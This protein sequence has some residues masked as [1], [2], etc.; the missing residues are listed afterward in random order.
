MFQLIY[1][2]VQF[3]RKCFSGWWD[4]VAW[5]RRIA[6]LDFLLSSRMQRKILVSSLHGWMHATFENLLTT[7]AKCHDELVETQ[8]I[9]VTIFKIAKVIEYGL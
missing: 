3:A 6:H 5:R 4:L 2:L 8:V 9:N 7:N 1:G